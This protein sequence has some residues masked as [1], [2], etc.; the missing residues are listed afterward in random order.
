MTGRKG[1]KRN[2]NFRQSMR[3][4][5]ERAVNEEGETTR[6]VKS[7]HHGGLGDRDALF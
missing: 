7:H 2:L 6:P 1:P 4:R 3:A 5:E